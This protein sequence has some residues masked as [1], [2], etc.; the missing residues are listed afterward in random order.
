M[1]VSQTPLYTQ[2]RGLLSIKQ[3]LIIKN[4][5]TLM[6]VFQLQ[7]L[8]SSFAR[9]LFHCFKSCMSLALSL[10]RALFASSRL[11]IYTLSG[12]PCLLFRLVWL[13]LGYATPTRLMSA[14]E[15]FPRSVEPLFSR[16]EERG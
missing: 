1:L 11:D 8:S 6:L 13:P 15:A 7:P 2:G 9:G 12:R 3:K 10:A 4:E 14:A 16:R 5:V